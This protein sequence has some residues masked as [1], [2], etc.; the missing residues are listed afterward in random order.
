MPMAQTWGWRRAFSSIVPSSSDS[1]AKPDAGAES[2]FDNE[3]LEEILAAMPTDFSAKG[4]QEK[5]VQY[6]RVPLQNSE[7]ATDIYVRKKAPFVRRE[8][9]S[10]GIRKDSNMK[11]YRKILHDSQFILVFQHFMGSEHFELWRAKVNSL[12]PSMRVHVHFKNAQFRYI[13]ANDKEG[14]LDT[15]QGLF[16]GP[17]SIVVGTNAERTIENIKSVMECKGDLV[18]LGGKV[19][20]SMI[21]HEQLKDLST[22]GSEDQIRSQIIDILLGAPRQLIRVLKNPTDNV[23]KVLNFKANP[24]PAEE[25]DAELVPDAA[26]AAAAP[27]AP[28]AGAEV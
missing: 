10:Y 1:V 16:K 21:T 4:L 14:E 15:M 2:E 22:A 7:G 6:D 18:W 25:G 9:T 24:E 20:N 5:G 17:V 23:I 13:L 28:A 3:Y 26:A 27:A 19:E 11:K 8:R 12:D